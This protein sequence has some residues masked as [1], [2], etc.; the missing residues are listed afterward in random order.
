MGQTIT[1]GSDIK[2]NVE[3]KPTEGYTLGNCDWEA[4]FFTPNRKDGIV[5][6]K[7]EGAYKVD[8]N[9]YVCVFNSADVGVGVVHVTLKVRIPDVQCPDG[10]RDEHVTIKTD[11]NIKSWDV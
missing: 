4:D 2:V 1:Q 5:T 8:D 6:I 11:I 7:K 9:N 10:F 3:M